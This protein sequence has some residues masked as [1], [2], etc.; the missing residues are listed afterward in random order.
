MSLDRRY[1]YQAIF[2]QLISGANFD[3]VGFAMPLLLKDIKLALDAG[4]QARAPMPM[5]SLV[6][7]RLLSALAK[8]RE[9]LDG[10]AFSLEAAEG[11]GLEWGKH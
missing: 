5:A 8:G 9:K 7:D 2:R 11:A 3:E 6:R 1:G 4:D 10:S